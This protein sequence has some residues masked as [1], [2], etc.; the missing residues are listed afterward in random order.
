MRGDRRGAVVGGVVVGSILGAGSCGA[1]ASTG[2]ATVGG[3]VGCC[4]ASHC[5]GDSLV[6]AVDVCVERFL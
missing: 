3:G 1:V 6:C 2:G 4:M 5:V